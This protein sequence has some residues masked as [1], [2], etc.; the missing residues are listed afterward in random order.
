MCTVNASVNFGVPPV[1]DKLQPLEAAFP[2]K[3]T[4]RQ[5]PMKAKAKHN[6]IFEKFI[7][8]GNKSVLNEELK[9]DKEEFM[10]KL[11]AEKD[12][13]DSR[14]NSACVKI[15][16]LF[17]GYSGRPASTSTYI[18]KR[19]LKKAP[20]QIQMHD[21]LCGMS[22]QLNFKPIVGL[23]LEPRSKSFRRRERF[24]NAA[25]FRITRFFKMITA[26]SLARVVCE[27][28]KMEIKNAAAC[29]ITRA[30]R[31]MKVKKFVKK[32]ETV[33][34]AAA[35]LVLQCSF[36]VF[37]ARHR[38]RDL[39]KL[40]V[41]FVRRSEC[42]IILQRNLAP[43]HQHNDLSR[44]TRLALRH[45][46]IMCNQV[47]DDIA[48]TMLNDAISMA[49]GFYLQHLNSKMDN[50]V[51][52]AMEALSEELLVALLLEEYAVE[53][54]AWRALDALTD[55]LIAAAEEE[56]EQQ[57]QQ[58]LHVYNGILDAVSTEETVL[59][60]SEAAVDRAMSRLTEQVVDD[61]VAEEARQRSLEE[62]LLELMNAQLA[63]EEERR[64]LATKIDSRA[65]EIESLSP[66]IMVSTTPPVNESTTPPVNVS[67]T[68]PVMVSTTPPVN[69]STTPPVNVSTTPLIEEV[70]FNIGESSAAYVSRIISNALDNL[71]VSSMSVGDVS[72]DATPRSLTGSCELKDTF[73]EVAP[74]ESM[75][76]AS[77]SSS[78]LDEASLVEDTA[79]PRVIGEW[80]IS[81]NFSPLLQL[82][83]TD[84]R[85]AD[86][87]FK[88][89][90]DAF[91]LAQYDYALSLLGEFT[92]INRIFASAGIQLDAEEDVMRFYTS[93]KLL[94]A[95]AL[96]EL[97]KY[98]EAKALLDEVLLQRSQLFGGAH[99]LTAEVCYHFAQW[100]L[101]QALYNEC[102]QILNKVRVVCSRCIIIVHMSHCSYLIRSVDM[103]GA[104]RTCEAGSS[105]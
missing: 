19:K 69:V 15:Q 35:V 91:V 43:K 9:R 56:E 84:K 7:M 82:E 100:C 29:T 3:K 96:F 10:S 58:V 75:T 5:N 102:E 88:K 68:P 80:E 71:K 51:R 87:W 38:V 86:A 73:D 81:R 44:V 42:A 62:Q 14:R 85:K 21:A 63:L 18:P 89:A 90:Y 41:V 48:D 34:R 60:V 64:Q 23:S 59:A 79:L 13:L 17:R 74:I 57:Q 98:A 50:A 24:L 92:V 76:A 36:R 97:A 65:D 33:K 32:C 45:V 67:T 52:I 46:L 16:A 53:T 83:A 47:L 30:V 20:T 28:K 55:E 94:Q 66:A 77:S 8:D 39:K 1:P 54:A 93:A 103:R 12:G 25:T 95:C 6:S 31:Y 61:A 4:Q 70:V 104:R 99:W 49:A 78:S 72:P 2:Y 40:R 101:S 105:R 22:D 11:Q 26:R 37:T 27:Q